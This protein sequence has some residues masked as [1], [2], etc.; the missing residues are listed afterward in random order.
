MNGNL[1]KIGKLFNESWENKKRLSDRISNPIVDNLYKI[2]LENGA[3]GGRL[4]GSGGGGYILFYYSPK[5]RKQLREALE[6]EGGEIMDF[7]FESQGVQ[8][9]PTK[10]NI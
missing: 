7:N 4:L 8:T 2:G 6:K 10:I 9:W 1:D 5:K 3:Q